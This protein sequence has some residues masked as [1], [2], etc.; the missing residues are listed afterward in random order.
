MI[1]E[2]IECHVEI[3]GRQFNARTKTPLCLKCRYLYR[4]CSNCGKRFKYDGRSQ[5]LECRPI[6]RCRRCGGTV[7]EENKRHCHSCIEIIG[8]ERDRAV[9]RRAS[10]EHYRAPTINL[11]G[12]YG[13]PCVYCGEYS[14]TVDHIMPIARGGLH[15]IENLVPAC[16]KCNG[17]KNAKLLT[18]WDPIRVAHGVAHSDRVSLIWVCLLA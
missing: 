7:S 16:G 14:N 10:N 12:I 6:R 9:A 17:S 3:N 18:E 11:D 4:D 15:V 2:C 8:S 1:G 5:C 13:A